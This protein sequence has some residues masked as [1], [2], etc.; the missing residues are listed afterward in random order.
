[1]SSWNPNIIEYPLNRFAH[2]FGQIIRSELSEPL[3]LNNN[4]LTP[5]RKTSSFLDPNL[6][7]SILYAPTPFLTLVEL[8]SFL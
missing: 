8:S 6:H 7:N 2:R 5:I 3:P 1:M 4:R